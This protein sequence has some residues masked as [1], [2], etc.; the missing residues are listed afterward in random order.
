MNFPVDID[1]ILSRL[2]PENVNDPNLRVSGETLLVYCIRLNAVE[3]VEKLLKLGVDVGLRSCG[4]LPIHISLD[5]RSETRI[6]DLILQY[7]PNG[8]L[9]GAMSGEIVGILNRLY[10][11]NRENDYARILLIA[12]R[13]GKSLEGSDY[14]SRTCFD[15][16]LHKCNYSENA[17]FYICKLIDFGVECSCTFENQHKYD[18]SRVELI[19]QVVKHRT[20]SRALSWT[21]LQLKRRASRLLGPGNGR[22]VLRIVSQHIWA[23]RLTL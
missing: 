11:Y 1:D 22:D 13:L 6:F 7:F 4:W 21:M 15:A 10:F 14:Y 17:L 3:A 9:E 12:C 16:V 19:A 8:G 5:Y 18:S 20:T 23:T 2:T